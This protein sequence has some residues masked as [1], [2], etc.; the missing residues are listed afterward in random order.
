MARSARPVALL[1]VMA[2]LAGCTGPGSDKAGGDPGT[3]AGRADAG[4]LHETGS[5][6]ISGIERY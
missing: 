1:A 3:P 2:V 6:L 4:Q 5:A